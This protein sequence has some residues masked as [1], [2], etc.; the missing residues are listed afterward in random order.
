[1][2]TV[3]GDYQIKECMLAGILY[4]HNSLLAFVEREKRLEKNAFM[5]VGVP[6]LHY[7]HDR[8]TFHV[9]LSLHDF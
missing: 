4:T 6:F 7:L 3:L 8:N 9:Q 2:F 5:A 1:M